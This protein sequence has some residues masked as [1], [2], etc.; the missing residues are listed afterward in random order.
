MIVKEYT[1]PQFKNKHKKVFN[2]L[3]K[4]LSPAIDFQDPDYIIRTLENRGQIIK[5]ELGYESD[6]EWNLR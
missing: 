2:E 5:A 1:I 4:P 3:F 6:L